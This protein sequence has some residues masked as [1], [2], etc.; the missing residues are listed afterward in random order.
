MTQII[1]LNEQPDNLINTL[2]DKEL[3]VYEDVQGSQIFVRWNG[4]KFVIKPKSISS[5]ELNF[6][7][8]AI[9]KFYNQVFQYLHTLPDYIT[10]LL[11][12]NWWFCFEYFPDNQPAHIEYAKLPKNNLILTCI[13]KGTRYKYNYNEIIEYAK[14]FNVDHLPIIFRGKLNEKQLEI[15]NLFL[16]TSEEDLEYVFGE[17]NFAYFFYKILNP[18]IE[19]SFLMD[20]FN[21]NME[22]IIIRI[23]GNDEYSFEI[24]NPYY[25]KMKLDNKTEYL[26]TYS[27]ILLNFLEFLQLINYDKLKLKE[28]TKDELYIELISTVF[29]EYIDNIKKDLKNW[30]L[31]IPSFF[32]NDKFRINT[33]LLKNNNTID[34]IKSDTKIE[35]IFKLVLS[36][37]NKKKKKPI[38]I[39]NEKT[40]ELFNKEVNKISDFIEQVLKINR[41]YLLRNN[42]LLN[43]KDYF[44]VNYNTD[45]QNMIYPDVDQI[46]DEI[47]GEEKKKKPTTLKKGGVSE[48]EEIKK[49]IK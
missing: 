34:L 8:L 29:N 27:L 39:F 4:S 43:F 24:L 47:P 13:V 9:Q 1:K 7:D 44:N 46:L 2:K 42:D 32:T 11:S 23:S 26:E 49:P 15:I 14:L 6:V 12:T 30:N 16:H 36:S 19:N 3:I 31:S 25:E 33:F 38:G 17:N 40:T 48:Y 41:E 35:Y 20:D 5:I 37:F 18:K 21:D 22:K 45:S 28:I 10:N